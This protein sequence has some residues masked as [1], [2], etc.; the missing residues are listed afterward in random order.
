MRGWWVLDVERKAMLRYMFVLCIIIEEN[1][2]KGFSL[3][4]YSLKGYNTVF[5]YIT[6]S[7]ALSKNLVGFASWNHQVKEM[8]V[9]LHA[10]TGCVCSYIF[11]K[12][13]LIVYINCLVLFS[14]YHNLI[15]METCWGIKADRYRR[16]QWTECVIVGSTPGN[17]MRRFS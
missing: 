17:N 8:K 1:F 16:L 12:Y 6:N 3:H 5:C 2:K 9:R 13:S 14:G 15:S 7:L 10:N 11:F 4:C